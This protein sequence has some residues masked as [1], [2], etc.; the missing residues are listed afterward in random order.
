MDNN[1]DFLG[2][3]NISSPEETEFKH[4]A[5]T[6]KGQR[7]RREVKKAQPRYKEEDLKQDSDIEE[8]PMAVP[9]SEVE[10][11]NQHNRPTAK[12]VEFG[13]ALRKRRAVSLGLSE[14]IIPPITKNVRAVYKLLSSGRPDPATKQLPE[15]KDA[16]YPATYTL[17]DRFE[18]DPIRRSKLMQNLGRMRVEFDEQLQKERRMYDKVE[19]EFIA[20]LKIVDVSRNYREYVFMELHPLNASNKFRDRSIQAEF[21][22]IDIKTNMTNAFEMAARDLG[23]RAELE[24]KNMKDQDLVIGYAVSFGIPTAGLRVDEIKAALRKAVNL[25]PKKFYS[26]AKNAEPGIQLNIQSALGLG[27]IVYEEDRRRFVFVNNGETFHTVLAGEDPV[28]SLTKS[29]V[30]EPEKMQLY[31]GLVEELN[32]WDNAA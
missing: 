21:E 4:N 17:D 31:E 7:E 28:E 2:V 10:N 27:M 9:V 3:D 22:R 29:I 32:Y 24:V 12:V 26:M 19:I 6:R 13:H 5:N 25:D 20:D 11:I 1:D 15:P 18:P 14:L 30:K 23:I 16:I 8:T